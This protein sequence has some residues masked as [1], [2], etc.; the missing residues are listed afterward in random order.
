MHFYIYPLSP[1]PPL[2]Y[3]MKLSSDYHATP[4]PVSAL[5]A[6]LEAGNIPPAGVE[7][8]QTV[9][10]L[11]TGSEAAD[12]LAGPDTMDSP[13]ALMGGM[14]G[15]GGEAMPDTAG[16]SEDS[17]GSYLQSMLPHASVEALEFVAVCLKLDP[18]ARP[19][20]ETLL[21]HEWLQ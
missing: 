12:T 2:I 14:G 4:V 9:T 19:T 10:G 20:A 15:M 7:P 6:L 18:R 5:G 3:Q 8:Y 21:A 16:V 1:M 11:Q 17:L 13:D